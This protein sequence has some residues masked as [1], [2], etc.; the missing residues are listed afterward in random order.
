MRRP[1]RPHGALGSLPE[2]PAS[3]WVNRLTEGV[4]RFRDASSESRDVGSTEGALRKGRR[5]GGAGG[6]LCLSSRSG[7]P[8]RH[9]LGRRGDSREAS[10]REPPGLG[11]G[12]ARSLETPAALRG[13][14]R[15][16]SVAWP[17]P[18]RRLPRS[19]GFSGA[20]RLCPGLRGSPEGSLSPS[21]PPAVL[22][23]RA[24]SVVLRSQVTGG[25]RV[26]DLGF[27]RPRSRQATKRAP[28]FSFIRG[29]ITPRSPG[30]F[31]DLS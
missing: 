4:L 14:P 16:P 24:V 27:V 28:P 5:G 25:R 3:L 2:P 26:S 1:P 17:T 8:S 22:N 23:R 13:D 12:G 21:L 9:C 30:R 18:V 31:K 29:L 15:C 6:A 11:S 10:G 19:S 7:P 20:D